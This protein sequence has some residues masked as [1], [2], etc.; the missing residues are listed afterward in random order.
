VPVTGIVAAANAS[1]HCGER[2]G[3]FSIYPAEEPVE[4]IGYS[5]CGGCPGGNVEYVPEEIKTAYN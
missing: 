2:R 5:S 1:A 3:A 4:I